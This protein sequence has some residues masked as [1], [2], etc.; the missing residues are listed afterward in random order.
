MI[1]P[2]AAFRETYCAANMIILRAAFGVDS[3][4]LCVKLGEGERGKDMAHRLPYHAEVC[5]GSIQGT[6][7][8]FFCGCNNFTPCSVR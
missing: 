8:P 1:I 3:C 2:R 5:A 6:A 4:G 7:S